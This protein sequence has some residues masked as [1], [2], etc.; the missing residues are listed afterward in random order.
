MSPTVNAIAYGTSETGR[1]RASRKRDPWV[2]GKERTEGKRDGR[3][4]EAG[5][6][7]P[8]G[9]DSTGKLINA[10]EN[11]AWARRNYVSRLYM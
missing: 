2:N 11:Y 10:Q 5:T 6:T 1:A 7:S 3:W 9:S 4:Q 8:W